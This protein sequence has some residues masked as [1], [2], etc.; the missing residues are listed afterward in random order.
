LPGVYFDVIQ[1]LVYPLLAFT[2]G[3]GDRDV[4]NAKQNLRF[5]VPDGYEVV[6]TVPAGADYAWLRPPEPNESLGFTIV[7]GI[8]P[9][10]MGR[11]EANPERLR[12]A[13]LKRAAPGATLS[14]RPLRWG[15]LDLFLTEVEQDKEGAG[16]V[17]TMGVIVPLSPS[18]VQFAVS[19]AVG[20][21][22]F[23]EKDLRSILSSVQGK[24]NWIP[25]YERIMILTGAVPMLLGWILWAVYGLVWL[26]L[27]RSHPLMA[28]KVRSIWLGSVSVLIMIGVAMS[29]VIDGFKDR[30]QSNGII[31][32]LVVIATAM[33][34]TKLWNAG[35]AT[36]STAPVPPAGL[37]PSPPAP[38]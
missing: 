29:L 27:Y 10:T 32:M 33:R 24:T 36:S 14:M 19:G 9:G 11:E 28:T 26:I 23:V 1:F 22:D 13:Y 12:T 30:T 5:R 7:V 37:P 8:L 20:R 16:R 38:A 31:G 4:W 3:S 35:P 15:E 34:A 18:A 17:V 2:L 21:R 25:Q 6:K